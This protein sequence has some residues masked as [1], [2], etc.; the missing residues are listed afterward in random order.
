MNPTDEAHLISAEPSVLP[1][2]QPSQG[3]R[4]ISKVLSPAI[5]LW[6]RAQVETMTGLK[7]EIRGSDREILRGRVPSVEVQAEQIV[8]QG[9]HLSQ[10]ALT[11]SQ[12]Q[13]N[14]RQVLQGKPLRLLEVV[15]VVGTVRLEQAALDA[16]MN[17][18][19]LKQALAD[20]L[21]LVLNHLNQELT[22]DLAAEL[23]ALQPIQLE[24]PQIQLANECFTLTANLLTPHRQQAQL[25][26]ET[27][28]QLIQGAQLQFT[29]LKLHYTSSQ[30]AAV[31]TTNQPLVIDLGSEVHLH[32]LEITVDG[33]SCQGR[34]NVTSAG[35]V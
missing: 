35:E 2:W 9:L 29:A 32:Q 18:P 26:L 15:P 5:Q 1:N 23:A 3:S 17:A 11:A 30:R 8:Y 21:T 14:L 34:M 20:F 24:H 6:L 33:V 16:S 19:L 28:L 22:S 31:I 4:V 27:Q 7:F 10:I 13:I 12:I 25:I